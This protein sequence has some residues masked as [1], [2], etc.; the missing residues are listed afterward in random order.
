MCLAVAGFVNATDLQLRSCSERSLRQRWT[1]LPDAR[2]FVPVAH[3]VDSYH[4]ERQ[5]ILGCEYSGDSHACAAADPRAKHSIAIKSE[6][7]FQIEVAALRELVARQ[8]QAREPPLYQFPSLIEGSVRQCDEAA[9]EGWTASVS[10]LTALRDRKFKDVVSKNT[11]SHWVDFATDAI[12]L[13]IRAFALVNITVIIGPSTMLGW[14]QG[15]RAPVQGDKIE[16]LVPVDSIRSMEHFYAIQ[17]G[18]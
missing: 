12:P 3:A 17:V 9:A 11:K 4:R 16:F 8:P 5:T 1:I 13:V 2:A 10:N 18:S 6:A 14:L 15:C 7:R